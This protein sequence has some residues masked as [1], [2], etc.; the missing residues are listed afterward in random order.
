MYVETVAF[1]K[2]AISRMQK[3]QLWPLVYQR[4]MKPHT[5]HYSI[6]Q[7]PVGN[8]ILSNM[9]EAISM[10]KLSIGS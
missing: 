8:L 9:K 5:D 1:N 2:D 7:Y 3:A 10:A 6:H 4:T